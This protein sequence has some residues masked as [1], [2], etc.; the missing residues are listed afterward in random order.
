MNGV[1][2][3]VLLITP[4]GRNAPGGIA[5]MADYC[6]RYWPEKSP[7]EFRVIDSYGP[8]S[9]LLM[10]F[11]ALR[12]FLVTAML[13]LARRGHLMHVNLS[14]RL[15]LWRKGA[16]IM[17]GNWFGIPVIIHLH[18]AEFAEYVRAGGDRR[19]QFARAL[20]GRAHKLIVLGSYWRTFLTGELGVDA[21]KIVVLCN[22]VPDMGTRK[23][24]NEGEECRILFLGVLGE[25]KGVPTL[26]QALAQPVMKSLRWRMIVAGNGVAE[27]YK[28]MAKELGIAERVEFPGLLAEP[29]ARAALEKTDIF[30]LPSRQEGLPMAILEAMSYG[31]AVVAT[32]VGSIPDAVIHEKTGLLVPVDGTAQLALALSR[33]IS[34]ASC[35]AQLGAQ[36]RRVFEEKF[37]IA[38]YN[39]ALERVYMEVFNAFR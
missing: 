12:A 4:G 10:P 37:S 18:G 15:S 16:F 11:F 5:R 6:V 8:G 24:R 14:E 20:L 29:Q 1:R 2:R 26:L 21:E 25:R 17:L 28:T 3:K 19:K 39:N 9:K 32:P 35:C 13:L 30:V 7:F 31:C 22:A 36:A 27:N 23:S 38:A 33:L 34:D